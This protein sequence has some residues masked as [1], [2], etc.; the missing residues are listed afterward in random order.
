MDIDQRPVKKLW[1]KIVAFLERE[2][3]FT[4]LF[5]LITFLIVLTAKVI[6]MVRILAIGGR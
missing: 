3:T 1:G 4:F 5:W 2:V 6:F